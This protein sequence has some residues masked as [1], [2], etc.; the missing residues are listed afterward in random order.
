MVVLP[1]C[2]QV[3][4]EHL[5]NSTERA[6]TLTGKAWNYCTLSMCMC[7]VHNSIVIS[8]SHIIIILFLSGSPEALTVCVRQMCNI[9]L[10]NPARGP[11]IPYKPMTLPNQPYQPRANVSLFVFFFLFFFF[12]FSLFFFSSCSPFC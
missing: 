4:G 11:H 2:A 10:D 9:M 8:K 1:V 7:C 6:V 3:A 12:F 5:P